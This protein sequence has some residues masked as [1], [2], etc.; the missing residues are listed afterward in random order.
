MQILFA[1][2]ILCF[3][4]VLWAAL[5]FARHIKRAARRNAPPAVATQSF[6]QVFAAAAAD[7]S[8]SPRTRAPQPQQSA[9]DISA[10]K[11]WDMPPKLSVLRRRT[12]T[13]IQQPAPETRKPPQSARHGKLTLLD[14]AYFNKDAGDLTD[15]HQSPRSRPRYASNR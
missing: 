6:S 11:H 12:L 3:L 8:P 13:P 2:S 14:P 10:G 5:A 1:I 7:P 9:H 15:P 4:A